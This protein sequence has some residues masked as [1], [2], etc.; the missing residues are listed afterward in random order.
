MII[1]PGLEKN[2][3]F[4]LHNLTPTN[5]RSYA[6]DRANQTIQP[7]HNCKCGQQ[8]KLPKTN[9]MAEIDFSE[10]YHIGPFGTWMIMQ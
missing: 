10:D 3:D 1:P 4:S 7:I 6:P 5:A 2:H 8:L 9:I